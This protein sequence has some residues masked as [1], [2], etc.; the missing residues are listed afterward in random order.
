MAHTIWHNIP[1]V[2]PTR[3]HSGCFKCT[4]LEASRI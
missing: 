4:T 3:G 2:A 1:F